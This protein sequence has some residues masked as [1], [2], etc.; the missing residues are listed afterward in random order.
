M[1]RLV[2]LLSAVLAGCGGASTPPPITEAQP[3]V[4]HIIVGRVQEIVL[5]NISKAANRYSY[6]VELVVQPTSIQPTPT[7]WAESLAPASETIRVR[8]HQSLGWRSLSP[9]EQA[10]VAPDGPKLRLTPTRWREFTVGEPVELRARH[11][12]AALFHRD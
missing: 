8:I 1:R 4:Q 11:S 10:A 7:L 2:T 6:N 9:D 3:A 12:S 5:Q